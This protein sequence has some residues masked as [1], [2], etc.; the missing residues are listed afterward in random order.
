MSGRSPFETAVALVEDWLDRG[1]GVKWAKRDVRVR[2]GNGVAWDIDLQDDSLPVRAVRLVLPPDFPASPCEFFVSRDLF[3]RIPHVESD[4]RLC[5][6]IESV[7]N[8]YDDPVSAVLRAVAQLESKL[9]APAASP[10]WV[11]EQ[12]HAERASYWG[13]YCLRRRK[14]RDHRPVP[15]RVY[16]NIDGLGTW[17]LGSTA[18]YFPSA[19]KHRRY[20]LEVITCKGTD[21]HELAGRH[22]WAD[23]TV[24]KG[25]ALLVRLPTEFPWTP[26][27]WPTT[28]ADLDSLVAHVT[29]HEVSVT[30]WLGQ[31]GVTDDKPPPFK[32]SKKARR[33]Q[34]KEAPPGQRPLTVVL[35]HGGVL[36]GFQVYA[37][38]IPIA[39]SP[40]IEPLHVTRVDPDWALA[41]DHH[42]RAMHSRRV[43]RVLLI[44]AGSLGSPVARLLARA[45]VGCIDIVDSQLMEP[46]NT[47]R[48]E[49]GL[50]HV[51]QGKAH[52]LAAE[53]AESVPGLRVKGFVAEA[54]T[55]ALKNCR[56][57]MYDL[58]VE[59]TAESSVRSFVTQA[60]AGLFGDVPVIHAW[61]EPLCSAAHAVLAQPQ[62]PWP[63]DDPADEL[64]NASDLSAADTRISVPACAGGFHPY[65]AADI[66][67]VAAFVVERILAVI[68]QPTM[69]STVWSWVRAK[70]YF[71]ALDRPVR[72]RAIVPTG[73]S[74]FDTATTS[75]LLSDVLK[76]R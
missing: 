44:G 24:V 71:D 61:T 9:L 34:P 60:R 18:A 57:G 48:H 58:V 25:D 30:S 49:L 38:S 66:T 19:S 26:A 73:G 42:V 69:P 45:G 31:V 37:P 29:E 54:S 43:H 36:F 40:A 76:S 7:P 28:Y 27:S 39:T 12:F 21:P 62:V 56:P 3:L 53:L 35:E 51:G 8:D 20:A 6:G 59:C 68:D 65:G 46:E 74:V 50:Q 52:A 22:R 47:S 16:A 72:V 11:A 15:A 33:D 17:S 4:G 67:Q 55:W 63:A 70:A 32:G 1:D 14:E 64:V 10:E 5:L 2:V 75:R 13:Q 41:R 23:G